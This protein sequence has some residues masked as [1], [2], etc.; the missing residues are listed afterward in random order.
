MQ[1][2]T[3]DRHTAGGFHHSSIRTR[4]LLGFICLSLVVSLIFV[5]YFYTISARQII[6][7]VGD[8]QSQRINNS[9]RIADIELS[10]VNSFLYW[11]IANEDLKDLLLRSPSDLGRFYGAKQSFYEDL[12][13]IHLYRQVKNRINALYILGNNGLQIRFGKNAYNTDLSS[14]LSDD[15][16]HRAVQSSGGIEW[17]P[18]IKNYSMVPLISTAAQLS[19]YIVPV[20][21]YVKYG[22]SDQIVGQIILLL[23]SDLLLYSTTDASDSTVDMVVDASGTVLACTHPDVAGLSVSD[24]AFYQKALMKRDGFFTVGVNGSSHLITSSHSSVSSNLLISLMP[25]SAVT[26]SMR[27][28]MQSCLLCLG[29]VMGF[30]ILASTYLSANLSRPIRE[31][32]G[33]IDEIS[34]GVFHNQPLKLPTWNIEEIAFLSSRLDVMERNLQTLIHERVVREQEKRVLEI[35]TLQSQ[36]SPHFLNNTI[37]SI[38]MMATMQGSEG[39]ARMLEALST[40]IASTV[41][42]SAEKVSLRDELSVV[43]AYL[44]IQRI[45]Y[46]GKVSCEVHVTDESL[47]QCQI[48]KFTLQPIVENAIFHGIAPKNSFGHIIIDIGKRKEDIRLSVAD[49]GVGIAPERVESLLNGPVRDDGGIL[50]GIGLS[51]VNRRLKLVYGEQYGLSIPLCPGLTKIVILI[52][53]EL[54]TAEEVQ[55]DDRSDC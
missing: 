11:L 21:K 23:D 9:V 1:Q 37:S 48:L 49:D 28:I 20:F 52:P 44:F 17:Y 7:S 46:R 33:R 8:S 4:F 5:F 24:E 41:Q 25:V 3:V 22:I 39:I 26:Q 51:N 36:I 32:V 40:I 12:N 47:L 54:P 6:Q 34:Q 29:I 19:D 50:H 14:L 43:D 31:V 42:N 38:R 18:A 13:N 53:T 27:S 35:R 2:P 45:R 55:A 30:S 15:W 16:Y 10:E